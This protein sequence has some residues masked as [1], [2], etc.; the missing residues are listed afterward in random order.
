MF[1]KLLR[2]HF[3]FDGTSHLPKPGCG[4]KAEN[5]QFDGY[6][7][8]HNLRVLPHAEALTDPDALTRML[9]ET[10]YWIDCA[11]TAND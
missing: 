11:I 5:V 10:S 4:W 3:L 7:A 8:S 1:L 2:K 9:G 6:Y